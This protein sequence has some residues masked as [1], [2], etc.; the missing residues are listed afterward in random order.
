MAAWTDPVVILAASSLAVSGLNVVGSW[1]LGTHDSTRDQSHDLAQLRRQYHGLRKMIEKGN[2]DSSKRHGWTTEHVGKLELEMAAM[3]REM[4]LSR[5]YRV[6]GD[7][8]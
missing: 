6:E 5:G 2:A 7:Q 4:M 3:K 8:V 1:M